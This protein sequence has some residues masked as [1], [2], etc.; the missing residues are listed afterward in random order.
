MKPKLLDLFCCE[1][2]A[3]VGY[4]M[5]GFEITGIDN[6]P[7]PKNQH[8]FIQNDA[9]EF[10]RLHGHEFDA[11]HA[12][13]PCQA[14]SRALKHLSSPK[15]MLINETRTLMVKS[16][17]PWI[18]ENVA[19]APLA[20][21]SDLFGNHGVQLC[22]TMFGLRVYRH[23]LFETSFQ[24]PSAPPCNHEITAMN[25]HNVKGREKI[26]AE[27]GRGDPEIKWQKEMGI[28]WMSRHGARQAVP[29]VF[30]HWIGKE[31]LKVL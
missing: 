1:G 29:P 6:E 18:I 21:D 19:G 8:A 7:Q 31:L 23:R 28:E 20:T 25:P 14:Y 2:G 16:G 30:T 10:L 27:M 5:A 22:G 12:S 4:A 11:I 17:K 9:L 15:Q 26:Y 3:G 24:L 13:P